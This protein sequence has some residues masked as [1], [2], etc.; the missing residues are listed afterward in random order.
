M[1]RILIFAG[2]MLVAVGAIAVP[3]PDV[4][5]EIPFECVLGGSTGSLDFTAAQ[6]L[7]G[8]D[9]TG[10]ICDMFWSTVM[11]F[12]LHANA[13]SCWLVETTHFVHQG[14]PAWTIP[15]SLNPSTCETWTAWFLWWPLDLGTTIRTLEIGARRSG[16]GDRAGTY[17]AEVT[18]VCEAC[19]VP[20]PDP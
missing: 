5:L 14:N 6:Q 18:I 19:Q 10:G 17:I 11:N 7:P 15:A 13:S 8:A 2:L 4:E 16:Y 9:S 20:I 1:K 3:V 12:T